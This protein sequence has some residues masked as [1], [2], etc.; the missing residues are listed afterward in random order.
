MDWLRMRAFRTS[1]AAFPNRLLVAIFDVSYCSE[2]R[3]NLFM[4]VGYGRIQGAL[5]ILCICILLLCSFQCGRA[6]PLVQFLYRKCGND[7]SFT[8]H[9]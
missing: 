5:Q 6:V 3:H 1:Q 4:P 2:K 8:G 7:S 9:L